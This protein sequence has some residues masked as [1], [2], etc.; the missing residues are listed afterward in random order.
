MLDKD[1]EENGEVVTS[2]KKEEKLV[3]SNK[4]E[5]YIEEDEMLDIA[6]KCFMRIADAI[7]AK[8]ITV[9]QAFKKHISKEVAQ[10]EGSDGGAEEEIELITPMGFL[11]GVKQL[12]ITDLQ[13]IDVACLMRILTKPDLE[14]AILLQELII[15]MENFG[16]QEA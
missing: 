12:G 8:N 10:T 7:I 11:E 3:N 15:I 14:N 5:A 13:E 6:E 9:R 2:G 16:I 1:D 4:D